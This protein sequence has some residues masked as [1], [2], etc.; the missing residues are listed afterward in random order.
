ME[1][2]DVHVAQ[3]LASRA[4]AAVNA[5]LLGE[6]GRPRFKAYRQLDTVEGKSN[7]AGIRWRTDHVEWFGLSLPALISLS[8]PVIKHG[9]ASRVK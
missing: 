3:K 5:W 1:H 2:L 9:L 7:H 8:D 4:F 6:R